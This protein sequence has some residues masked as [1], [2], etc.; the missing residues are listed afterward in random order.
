MYL[1]C[2]PDLHNKVVPLQQISKVFL[3]WVIGKKME[4][5]KA[6]HFKGKLTTH[7]AAPANAIL[8][9]IEVLKYRIRYSPTRIQEPL[10]RPELVRSCRYAW[11]VDPEKHHLNCS[12]FFQVWDVTKNLPWAHK[13]SDFH[14]ETRRIFHDEPLSRQD[15]ELAMHRGEGILEKGTRALKSCRGI[16]INSSDYRNS[17]V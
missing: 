15:I 13:L 1:P 16:F 4:K 2:E 17:V 11:D 10:A 14:R 5:L 7:D 8:A 6:F 9:G 3:Q 12:T